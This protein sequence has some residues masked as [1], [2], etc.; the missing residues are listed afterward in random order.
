MCPAAC[1]VGFT[2]LVSSTASSHLFSTPP[3]PHIH[4]DTQALFCL[5]MYVFFYV[6]T[7]LCIYVSMHVCIV[8]LYTHTDN[9]SCPLPPSH[10]VSPSPVPKAPNFRPTSY[11]PGGGVS[12]IVCQHTHSAPVLPQKSLRSRAS[13]SGKSCST[14]ILNIRRRSRRLSMVDKACGL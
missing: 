11:G 4:T 9:Y 3:P 7:Y 14:T 1:G 10:R 12:M 5:C 8:Y 2:D 13:V 6:C